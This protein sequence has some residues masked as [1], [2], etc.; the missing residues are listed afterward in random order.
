M[1]RHIILAQSEVTASVLRQVLRLA[2][3]TWS[4]TGCNEPKIVWEDERLDVEAYRLI[5]DKLESLATGPQ[6][7]ISLDEV[8]VLVDQVNLSQLDPTTESGWNGVLAML[9]LTFPEFRWVFGVMQGGTAVEKSGDVRAEE[10]E[11]NRVLAAL[12]RSHGLLALFAPSSDPL[13]DATGLRNW[14]RQRARVNV[15][16]KYTEYLP[17]RE[18][19]AVAI[20]DEESYA[21]FNAYVA[22]RFGSRSHVVTSYKL[23]GA[24]FG[25]KASVSG[26]QSGEFSRFLVSFED[27]FLNFPDRSKQNLSLDGKEV[28]V[29]RLSERDRLYPGLAL[30]ENRIFITSG[31]NRGRDWE[32]WE[33][34]RQHLEGWKSK[35]ATDRWSKRLWKPLAGMFNLW[36]DSGLQRRMRQRNAYEDEKLSRAHRDLALGYVWP[37]LKDDD[38]TEAT[39]HSAPGRLLAVGAMLLKRTESLLRE[40]NSVSEALQGAVLATDA[41]ELLGNR[42]PTTSMQALAL[43]HQFEVIA[44]CRFFG[45]DYSLDVQGRFDDIEREVKAIGRWFHPRRRKQ[46]NLD[47]ELAITRQLILVFREHNQFDEE[48]ECLIHSRNLYR[49]L[50]FSQH[51]VALP[52]LPLAWYVS[53]LLASIPRFVACLFG[54]VLTFAFIFWASGATNTISGGTDAGSVR[55]TFWSS[56][57]KSMETCFSVQSVQGPFSIWNELA[58]L[59]AFLHLGVFISHLY[60]IVTRR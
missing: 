8:T 4:G 47:A 22:Y 28:H 2:T 58:I 44:E 51:P 36:R 10:E 16:E 53:L 37:P 31:A 29:S 33:G 54:W 48:Q 26:E 9:I 38:S 40:V 59:G 12:E 49:R 56:L 17:V 46:S 25:R 60:S 35:P 24:L 55:L 15:K 11:T 20:D 45:I 21:Y 32:L 3:P 7:V 57:Q 18:Q 13:F 5:T 50:W 43:K 19:A 39:G 34:N 6:G 14:V 41:M 42:V 52:F 30:A 1:A 27:L 23:M